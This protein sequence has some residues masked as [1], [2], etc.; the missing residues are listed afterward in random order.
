[1][2]LRSFHYRCSLSPP[3]SPS[4]HQESAFGYISVLP[5]AFSAYRYI[6]LTNGPDG[7]GPLQKYFL[8]ETLHGGDAGVFTKNMCTSSAPFPTMSRLP[9][10]Q[11]ICLS[12]SRLNRPC[13]GRESTSRYERPT[14]TDM[15]SYSLSTANP[16]LRADLRSEAV[17]APLRSRSRRRDRR[18]RRLY[19]VSTTSR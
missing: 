5:G 8:G 12:L 3:R 16:L 4:T 9:A 14:C 15:T 11:L 18:T 19:R 13:R 10:G 6:A 7:L 17:G 1:M 2:I